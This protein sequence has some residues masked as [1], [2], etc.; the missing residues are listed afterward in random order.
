MDGLV[1]IILVVIIVIGAV[2]LFR[3]RE[4][5]RSA[6]GAPAR[7]EGPT[8]PPMS[9][10]DDPD[11]VDEATQMVSVIGGQV[12]PGDAVTVHINDPEP[13]GLAS[14]DLDV[15]IGAVSRAEIRDATG[16]FSFMVYWMP[17]GQEAAVLMVEGD[18]VVLA[19]AFVGR[20]ERNEAL[21]SALL[22]CRD[23]YMAD[24]VHSELDFDLSEHGLGSW[25]AFSAREGGTLR[26]ESG[27]A[28]LLSAGTTVGTGL[29]YRDF[30]LRP[31][32]ATSPNRLRLVQVGGYSY[33]FAG[34]V[35]PLRD[36]N[37]MRRTAG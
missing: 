37:I 26:V 17:T 16:V 11:R 12:R 7:R 32:G 27:T 20:L 1:T 6:S 9:R 8:P 19:E 3:T 5:G 18:V 33:L 10:P 13:W 35:L 36:V 4:S 25:T 2:Y 31:S 30:T 29:P 22:W 14:F 21:V 24:T 34:E 15:S 28:P 23:Q